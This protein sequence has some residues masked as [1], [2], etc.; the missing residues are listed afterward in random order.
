IIAFGGDVV[1]FAGD[2]LLCVWP[3]DPTLFDDLEKQQKDL[4]QLT[5]LATRCALDIQT[6]YND[7]RKQQKKNGA[8]DPE[9]R[10][11]LG[12]GAGK[13][14]LLIVGGKLGRCEY[15]V[16]GDALMQA[17]KCETD[18]LPEQ[19]VIS[20][21]ARDVLGDL[22]QHKGIP[23]SK[24][25]NV[26]VTSAKPIRREHFEKL[27]VTPELANKMKGYIP[28][29][30]RPH[31]DMPSTLWTGE[32]REVTVLFI[33]LP[34]EAEILEDLVK[35]RQ[36]NVLYTV[37]KNIKVLQNVIYKY[38]GS[39]NK[40]L[41]DDKGS[42]VMA[43]FGLPPVAHSNDPVRAVL[44]ALELNKR[45]SR[46][47]KHSY[48]ALG[49]AS[50]IVF[51][52]LIGGT[53]GT[54]R[55]YTVLGSQVN[56]A[57][58]LMGLAKKNAHLGHV[59]C[60]RSVYEKAQKEIR[61]AWSELGTSLLKGLE[62]PVEIFRPML[63]NYEIVPFKPGYAKN[64]K[65]SD[66]D[67]INK[68]SLCI[69][70]AL[71]S[72]EAQ[73][74]FVEGEIAVGKSTLLAQ[75]K[76]SNQ[77]KAWFLWGHA[78]CFHSL[79]KLNYVVWRQVMLEFSQKYS[80]S[81][82]RNRFQLQTWVKQRRPDL[83]KYL[84]L[85]TDILEMGT[86]L[87]VPFKKN[88]NAISPHVSKETLFQYRHDLL[89]C[90]LEWVSRKRLLAIV[91]DEIQYLDSRDWQLTRR[92]SM[93]IHKKVVK[94]VVLLLGGMPM[95]NR[96]YVPHFTQPKRIFEYCDLRSMAQTF[97]SPQLWT[98]HQTKEWII[99]SSDVKD[100]SKHLVDT[101][102]FECGGRPGFCTEFLR[103]LKDAKEP[104]VQV[105]VNKSDQSDKI[106]TFNET[107][108]EKLKVGVDVPFPIPPYIQSI[109]AAHLDCI[110][111]ELVMCMKTAAVICKAK[112]NR[113]RQ[114]EEEM[115]RGTH[116]VEGMAE[117][118]KLRKSL[119]EL[120]NMGFIVFID[121][122]SRGLAHATSL[123]AP[124][125]NEDGTHNR[126]N[127]H[128]TSTPRSIE[129]VTSL[130]NISLAFT[131]KQDATTTTVD[132]DNKNTPKDTDMFVVN[133][134]NAVTERDDTV[135]TTHEHDHERDDD[136]DEDN[137][138][139]Q[140]D[141]TINIQATSNEDG[142]D[143]TTTEG[144]EDS[145]VSFSKKL[146]TNNHLDSPMGVGGGDNNNDPMPSTL[147]LLQVPAI[148]VPYK[149]GRMFKRS[150]ATFNFSEKERYFVFKHHTLYWFKDPGKEQ[151]PVN[152]IKFGPGLGIKLRREDEN[153]LK[154]Q[155]SRKNYVLR[156]EKSKDMNEWYELFKKALKGDKET[157]NSPNANANSIMDHSAKIDF[158]TS[159]SDLLESVENEHSDS[160][161]DYSDC[162]VYE[163]SYGF[164][165]D[166]I[167]EQMLHAQRQQ[168]HNQAKKYIDQLLSK[169]YDRNLALLRERHQELGSEK[170]PS[171]KKEDELFVSH[172]KLKKKRQSKYMPNMYV[173]DIK[174]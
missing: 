84:Y 172:S 20:K 67:S 110:G 7:N 95:D 121:S 24:Y 47:S 73:I 22:C 85:L 33:S 113:S 125:M 59:I 144:G 155:T 6:E 104:W 107:I 100:C 151:Y 87:E 46:L 19:V 149:K 51:S 128:D 164:L 18:C 50:G 48:A 101:V 76:A 163:F 36:S 108:E 165:R 167:Y 153:Q 119:S 173:Q 78:D 96:R 168:L 89:I 102:Y 83:E 169:S 28:S 42:T 134:R 66:Y 15:L 40:F 97:V 103:A 75:I 54:R 174:K 69:D 1:K 157:L 39:L 127:D 77:H 109:T 162:H 11:K 68:A 55:E 62:E 64:L 99:N 88:I 138:H 71:Q 91:L 58:R 143:T 147:S 10:V 90:L 23:T 43:V 135:D 44:A 115:L 53:F 161:G 52:G 72:R 61:I 60:D 92:L 98:W 63:A 136:H 118:H 130:T 32:L 56:L 133:L 8:E 45:F 94:N 35:N 30:V 124:S 131:K 140:L 12:I 158:T 9:L 137:E 14:S 156:A 27:N 70:K 154:V 21:E 34:F 80:L 112:G 114:F 41:V 82:R 141:V 57:A 123:R 159:G 171:R 170:E 74:I 31:L 145:L 2:A 120:R 146:S 37:Q 152:R 65:T 81:L 116:P 117:K 93:L 148:D 49:L 4:E 150:V 129:N 13:C 25:G 142:P 126:S 106:I 86:E 17:F 160:E 111:T 5:H 79:S 38:Q 132:I 16:C 29:A 122:T 139:K 3:P 166:V 26:L 105:L